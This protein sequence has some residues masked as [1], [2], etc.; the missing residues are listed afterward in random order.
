MFSPSHLL[1]GQS[2]KQIYECDDDEVLCVDS[3][4]GSIGTSFL[5][6][7]QIAFLDEAFAFLS[8]IWP[9][10]MLYLV[11]VLLFIGI[12]AFVVLNMLIGVICD[13]VSDATQQGRNK[14]LKERIDEIFQDIDPMCTGCISMSQFP[15]PDEVVRKASRMT[16]KQ[17]TPSTRMEAL[18]VNRQLLEMS[19]QMLNGGELVDTASFPA[20]DV[21]NMIFKLR[22]PPEAEDLMIINQRLV[23][24]ADLL[25]CG[26]PRRSPSR[27]MSSTKL[28]DA[29]IVTP[30]DNPDG[31]GGT[32]EADQAPPEELNPVVSKKTTYVDFQTG[33]VVNTLLNGGICAKI[34]SNHYTEKFTLLVIGINPCG[35][36]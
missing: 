7:T 12:E 29:A 14:A 31:N 19:F 32:E 28:G 26:S 6:L 33:R 23:R 5:S 21:M 22:N 17:V 16:A 35:L 25:S 13:I 11:L 10:S 20:A 30:R 1:N 2:H 8:S 24:M 15:P 3:M 4:F 27:T 36:A 34:A 9:E 18:G